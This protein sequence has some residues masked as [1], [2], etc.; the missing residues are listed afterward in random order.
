MTIIYAPTPESPLT[1]TQ[2]IRNQRLYMLQ[3][4]DWTVAT[5]SPLS[6]E[7]KDRMGN[8]QASIKRLTITIHRF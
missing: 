8:I 2:K 4:C 1:T 6:V 3:G 7:K 5:D